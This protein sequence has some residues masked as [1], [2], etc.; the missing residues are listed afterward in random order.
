MVSEGDGGPRHMVGAQGVGYPWQV[1]S[2]RRRSIAVLA[3]CVLGSAAINVG[4]FH[5]IGLLMEAKIPPQEEEITYLDLRPE[6]D[7]V[8]EPPKIRKPS[9]RAFAMA[10]HDTT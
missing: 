8:A 10:P 6:S 1:P 5:G 7:V 4:A 9:R 3:L 2:R